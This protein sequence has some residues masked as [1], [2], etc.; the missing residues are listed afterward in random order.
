VDGNRAAVIYQY[1][2]STGPAG[3]YKQTLSFVKQDGR[4]L[5]D[6]FSSPKEIPAQD[7]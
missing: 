2:T 3:T 4:L 7:A 6:S 5:I 1:A